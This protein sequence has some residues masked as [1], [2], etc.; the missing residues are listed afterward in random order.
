MPGKYGYIRVSTKE[1]NEDRQRIALTEAGISPRHLYIDKESGKDFNRPQY[2]KLIKKLKPGDILYI[3]SIDRLGR[4]YKEILTQWRIITKDKGVDICVLDMPLLD[5]LKNKDLAGTLI[6]DIILQL[7]SYVAE[8]ERN[9]IRQRQAEGIAAAKARGKL[10][11][12]PK[13]ELDQNFFDA[14]KAWKSGQMT[15]KQ[16]A[17]SCDMNLSNFR[18]HAGKQ[19]DK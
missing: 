9:M 6:A 14:L 10:W 13:R 15:C 11:G 5:T 4:N 3:K 18:Y 17:Q 19:P 12:R 16:A 2:I 8:T 1:Q 7:L